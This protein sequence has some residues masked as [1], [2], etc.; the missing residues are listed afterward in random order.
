MKFLYLS[1]LLLFSLSLWAQNAPENTTLTD[2]EKAYYETK[3]SKARLEYA[4]AMLEYAKEALPNQDTTY[5][6]I[7]HRVAKSYFKQRNIPKALEYLEEAQAIQEQ[8]E[9][10]SGLYASTLHLLG[11]IYFRRNDLEKVEGYWLKALAIREQLYGKKDPS[12]ARSLNNLGA[13]YL[14]KGVYEKAEAYFLESLAIKKAVRGEDDPSL[15]NNIGNLANLYS[16]MGDYSK[17]ETFYFQ[18]MEHSKKYDGENSLTYA[19]SLNNL[20]TLYHEMNDEIQARNYFEQSLAVKKKVAGKNSSEYA[21]GLMGLAATYSDESLEVV[22]KEALYQQAR[23]IMKANG[24]TNAPS[25]ANLLNNLG[26]LYQTY[27]PLEGAQELLEES[28]M[29]SEQLYGKK[30]ANYLLGINNLGAVYCNSKQFDKG[31]E[32]L[33]EAININTG[34]ALTMPI[35]QGWKDQVKNGTI[36]SWQQL[37]GSLNILYGA[38]ED[39][40]TSTIK[41]EA[42]ILAEIIF[43]VLEQAKNERSEKSD[44]IRLLKT[45]T[46]WV[47]KALSVLEEADAEKA[48][49]IIEQNKSL[50]LLDVASTKQAYLDGLLPKNLVQEEKKLQ[51]K[52]TRAKA[53]IIQQGLEGDL[54]ALRTEFNEISLELDEFKNKVAKDYPKY[55]AM[56]Y[57]HPTVKLKEVQANLDDKTAIVQYFAG[58][59]ITCIIYVDKNQVKYHK[60]PNGLKELRQKVNKMHQALSDYNLL[61]SEPELSY[62]NYTRNAWWWYEK[63]LEPVLK[64]KVEGIEHLVII[65]D[66]E[67]GHLPFETFL[68]EQ[69]PQNMSPYQDL[70]YL[71]NKYTVS[72]NYSATLWKQ[73]LRMDSR[74]NNG[75]VLG[76]AGN[77]TGYE[78][79]LSHRLPKDM[80]VREDLTSLPAA[81][82]EVKS[83]EKAFDGFFAFD[84]LASER[85]FKE[86][87]SAYSVIHLAMHGLLDRNENMLSSLVFTE[88]GDQEEN[89]FLHAYEIAKM[90]L[91]AD[92]VVLSACETGYGRFE[93]GNG[94]G[95]LASAFACAG[96]PAMVVSLWQVNDQTTYMIIQEFYQNL[97]QGMNK[98]KALQQAKLTYL[99]EAGSVSGHPAFWSPFI[100]MGNTNPILIEVQGNKSIIWM[101]GLLLGIVLLGV[102]WRFQK[103]ALI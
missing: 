55:A 52:Y 61:S 48:F 47:Y 56:K 6:K 89:N 49:D 87:A 42:I 88:D 4:L 35:D 43:D 91:N 40:P 65:P 36:I 84:S 1:F 17:A 97:A 72:Y 24:A 67:L 13:L 20:G 66:K 68:T 29:I 78:G 11:N 76:M 102:F 94:I 79:D 21:T 25:Y 19:N 70:A 28:K 58:Y 54:D 15:F 5:A 74:P 2:L 30:H 92:L 63:L 100:M 16:E 81:R 8:E 32:Y 95:S 46:R 39:M 96:V 44:K 86:K 80:R 75:Q 18:A 101:G 23:R 98:D 31:L 53:A 22:N 37:E 85:I 34:L 62:S 64:N 9:T 57:Y 83:L 90:D 73:N 71:I 14:V 7:L 82:N 33:L 41:N 26:V 27:K 3:D 45:R 93:Y 99:K 69:A 50:L 38:L 51:H 103:R 60:Y 77:Y 10:P 59:D 12:Y